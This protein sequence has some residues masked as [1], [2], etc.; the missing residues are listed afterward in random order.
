MVCNE[1]SSSLMLKMLNNKHII[2]THM[3]NSQWLLKY[4]LILIRLS[5][6]ADRRTNDFLLSSPVSLSLLIGIYLYV[7][8]VTA[9]NFMRNRKPFNLRNILIVYNIF[10]ILAN[11]YLSEKV[12]STKNPSNTSRQ[13][14]CYC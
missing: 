13:V 8:K 7:V 14:F 12:V 1:S 5:S 4:F 2:P 3:S 10:Q 11:I 9:P 6:F